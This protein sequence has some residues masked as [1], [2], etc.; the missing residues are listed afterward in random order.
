MTLK[1]LFFKVCF[2]DFMKRIWSFACFFV[3]L[4]FAFPV[5]ILLAAQN[6]R[7]N[8]WLTKAEYQSRMLTYYKENVYGFENELLLLFLAAAAILLAINGFSYLNSRKKVDYIH[9]MPIKRESLFFAKYLVGVVT[10][11]IPLVINMGIGFAVIAANGEF[12]WDIFKSAVAYLGIHFVYFLLFYS[13]AVLAVVL[14]GN[15]VVSFLGIFVFYVYQTLVCLLIMVFKEIFF[16]NYNG[17]YETLTAYDPLAL[18]LRQSREVGK[19]TESAADSYEVIIHYGKTLTPMWIAIG[20]T[21]VVVIAAM[22]LFKKRPS[23][24]AGKALVFPV[25]EPIIK[26]ALLVPCVMGGGMVMYGIS[27][28]YSIGWYVFGAVISFV[29][30]ALIFE[31][32]FR[33]DFKGALKHKV[34]AMA[35]GALILFCSLFFFMDLGNFDGRLP[36][37]KDVVSMG[38]SFKNLGMETYAQD[39]FL[40]KVELQ[41]E[42]LE[43]AYDFAEYL[44]ENYVEDFTEVMTANGEWEREQI[45]VDVCYRL[46]NGTEIYRTYGVHCEETF[47]TLAD[48]VYL[49]ESYKKKAFPVF[50]DDHAYDSLWYSQLLYDEGMR[51][52][53][54]ERQEFL[55]V[56]QEDVK[57]LT[58]TDAIQEG[59]VLTFG[60]SHSR[61]AQNTES[62]YP[63]YADFEKTIAYLEKLGV[64]TEIDYEKLVIYNLVVYNYDMEKDG[65]GETTYSDPVQQRRILEGCVKEA[66]SSWYIAGGV[67]KGYQVMVDYEYGD[68]SGYVDLFL[69]EVPDFVKADFR[70]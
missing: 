2:H 6:F 5:H 14:V 52:T 48:K 42:D 23:E 60:L 37:E 7:D 26:V 46:K 44:V 1:N 39:S 50:E 29:L 43:N 68:H 33:L 57:E 55:K 18:L 27:H 19:Y 62:A 31:M 40:E 17:Q 63:V 3:V 21:A 59:T 25:S 65:Y 28:A 69:E 32:I 35:A 41:G 20:I 54:Q 64:S 8:D 30:L 24:S 56:Y 70:D 51:I 61:L 53:D 10:Y 11:L 13:V 4:F 22:F 66:P 47:M 15:L 36:K 49:S 9:S 12:Q 58:F 67:E 45:F 16:T 34:S 38:I